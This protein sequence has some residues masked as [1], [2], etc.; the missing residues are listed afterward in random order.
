[1]S[2]AGAQIRRKPKPEFTR[3]D[4]EL[5]GV[6]TQDGLVYSLNRSA[7]RVWELLG[8]WTTV[9]T[10]CARLREEYEVD[11]DACAGQVQKLVAQLADAG[12]LERQ[13]G[14]A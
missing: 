12:L 4:D 1:M 9:D 14:E 8:D 10:I 13:G 2:A 6:D 3:V 7:A 11:P 5:L